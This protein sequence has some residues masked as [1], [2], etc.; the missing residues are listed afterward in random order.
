MLELLILVFVIGAVVLTA[1]LVFGLLG[2]VFHLVLLPIK[3]LAGLFLFL[4]ALPL[5]LLL[6]PL[7]VVAAVG[8]GLSL[9][10]G[11]LLLVLGLI[12]AL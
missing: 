3:L 11:G 12:F 10:V 6:V 4:L 9:L 5:L 7:A 8:L 2:L 1:K